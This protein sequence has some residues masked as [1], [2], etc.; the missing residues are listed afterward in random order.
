M[1]D[2]ALGD[3]DIVL[4]VTDLTVRARNKLILDKVSFYVKRGTT[5]AIVGPNGSGKTILLKTLLGVIPYEGKIEWREGTR[6]G[7][8]PQYF[9]VGDIPMSVRDFLN[10]KCKSNLA[11][12]LSSVRLDSKETLDKAMN[13]LSG[14]EL[15]RVLIAWAIVDNPDV[16]LFDEPTTG[17]DVGNVELIYEALNKLKKQL[18]ITTLLVTHDV[19]IM[20]HY[21]D[22]TLALK[23]RAVFLVS[24]RRSQAIR[25]FFRKYSK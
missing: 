11:G 13:V 1:Y 15:Q 6:I 21:T 24:P 8:V 9:A 17:V 14:G 22:Y 7:Y 12:C 4:R 18:S 19:H 5:L 3:Q 16:L 23:N 20:H 25:S 2:S 10:I